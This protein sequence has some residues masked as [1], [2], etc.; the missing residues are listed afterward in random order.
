VLKKKDRGERRMRIAWTGEIGVEGAEGVSGIAYQ[1]RSSLVRRGHEIDAFFPLVDRMPSEFAGEP[2]P[3]LR[4]H[5]ADTGWR[6]DHWYAQGPLRTFISTSA[7]RGLQVFA[8]AASVI[9]AHRDRKYDVI[10]QMS[11]LEHALPKDVTARPPLVIHPC[12][13]ARA[14]AGWHLAEREL[15]LSCESRARFAVVQSALRARSWIQPHPARRADLLIGPSHRFGR[16]AADALGVDPTKIAVLR[17]PVDVSQFRPVDAIRDERRRELLFVG[18]LATRKGLELILDLSHRLDDLAGRV[19]LTIAGEGR[20]W[21]DYSLLLGRANARVA[22]AVGHLPHDAVVGRMQQAAA[23]I[24]PSRFEP[25]SIAAGE[26][27]ACGL[28]VIAS[29]QVGP[30]EILDS[31]CGRVF[32]D[33]D[34]ASLETATRSLLAELATSEE[35][36]RGRARARALEHLSTNVVVDRLEVLLEQA[37]AQEPAT[38]L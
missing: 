21:S 35:A 5:A 16:L 11:Q 3:G 1:L 19:R 20:W 4:I 2:M 32:R 29:D 28:P 18:R 15:A 17:H 14:E 24:V 13:L 6:S 25:G 8:T 30:S 38:R 22:D 9:R 27:L 34:A 26:A 12:T 7:V 36:V 33:G 37:I 23:L 31:T 10:F